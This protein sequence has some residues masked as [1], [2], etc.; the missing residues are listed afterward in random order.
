VDEAPKPYNAREG[1]QGIIALLERSVKTKETRLLMGRLMRQTAQLRSH[2]TAADLDNF[3]STY[4][5]D[6]STSAPYL[7][8]YIKQVGGAAGGH[9]YAAVGQAAGVV[10]ALVVR[11]YWYL[12]KDTS[13]SLQRCSCPPLVM[14]L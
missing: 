10:E 8:G 14:Q 1:M 3:I 6:D 5:P 7:A 2:M 12:E 11:K 9:A 13:L 4:L